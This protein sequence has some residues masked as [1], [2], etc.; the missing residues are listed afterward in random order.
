MIKYVMEAEKI[1]LYRIDFSDKLNFLK[2][3]ERFKI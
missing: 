3:S 1:V 2:N